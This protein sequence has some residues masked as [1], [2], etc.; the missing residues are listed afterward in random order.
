M[1]ATTL[2][3]LPAVVY[4]ATFLPWFV[5]G[6]TLVDWAGLQ[7]DMLRESVHH[8]GYNAFLYQLET[9]PAMW[10]LKPTAYVDYVLGAGAPTV[11]IGVGSPAV[12]LLTWPAL[13][14][15]GRQAWRERRLG[16]MLVLALFFVPYT[17]LAL[18]SR[19]IW[20]HTSFAVLPFAFAAVAFA[21][22]DVLAR[23]RRGRLWLGLYLA[24]VLLSAGPLYVLAIGRGLEV[25]ALRPLVLRYQPGTGR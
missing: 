5:R 14:W 12:W 15:T 19:P 18:A 16:L 25:E 20:A 21:L 2:V 10:F 22:L 11:L 1:I 24:A 6:Y 7:A 9:R 4:L 23:L 13:A 8:Q 3:L 17:P